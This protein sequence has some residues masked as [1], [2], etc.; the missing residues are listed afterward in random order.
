MGSNPTPGTSNPYN[1][2]DIRWHV[3]YVPVR[4]Y[5]FIPGRFP[6]HCRE[7]LALIWHCHFPKAGDSQ[8]P[9]PLPEQY[10]ANSPKGEDLKLEGMR[11]AF[12]GLAVAGSNPD[13]LADHGALSACALGGGLLI[14]WF[15]VRVPDGP[16]GL[17][18][19]SHLKSVSCALFSFWLISANAPCLGYDHA[20]FG[21]DC[22]NT[23]VNGC[24]LFSDDK[25]DCDRW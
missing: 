24:G 10:S 12:T 19:V 1:T 17:W 6:V 8:S 2:N 3:R 18:G 20:R 11:K 23:V 22:V 7:I 13:S 16:P 14:R 5:C 4:T 25:H 15:G 9:A 21:Y